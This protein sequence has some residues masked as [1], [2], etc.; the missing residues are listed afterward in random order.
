MFSRKSLTLLLLAACS[1]ACHAAEDEGGVTPY[2]P[3]VSTPAQL[4]VP[5]QLELELGGFATQDM[6]GRSN[7]VPYLFKLAFNRDWG[8]LLGGDAYV[9]TPDGN[10]GRAR[11]IGDTSVTLKRAFTVDDSTVYGL[12]L[13]AKVPTASTA[14][15]S[16]KADWTVNAIASKDLDKWHIDLN[17]DGTRL[18]APDPGASRLQLGASA[19]FSHPLADERWTGTIELSGIHNAGAPSTAQVL[20]ALSYAPTKQL[21]MDVG[22]ARGLNPASP[23]WSLF[24]GFVAPL[25]RLW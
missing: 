7:S 9:S 8:L 5:G 1:L 4:P 18:G 13:T 22:V 3:S 11:G 2:R 12:E 25:A 6:D 23:N 21:T 24:T 15:G 19:A 10:G 17:L 14:I 20:A 16:G